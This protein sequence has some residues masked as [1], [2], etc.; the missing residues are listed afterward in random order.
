MFGNVQT[1][2]VGKNMSQGYN[3]RWSK[4]IDNI[5]CIGGWI[6]KINCLKIESLQMSLCLVR[7]G[8]VK[9]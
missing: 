5:F 6:A 2:I 8:E 4:C 3:I 7:S 9:R 1:A